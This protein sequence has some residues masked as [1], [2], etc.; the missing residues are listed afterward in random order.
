MDHLQRQNITVQPVFGGNQEGI[1][2]Q[3]QA[4]KVVAACVNDQVMQLFAHRTKLNYRVLWESVPFENLPIAVHPRVK[5]GVVD[6]VQQAFA[7]LH[8]TTEGQTILEESAK[9]IN[10][11]PPYGFLT[12][13]QE[14]YRNYIEFYNATIVKDYE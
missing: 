9:V 11:E 1:M 12:A 5:Q 7:S 3:L 13:S 4:G 10:Q 6:Q 8:T 2:G 14:D